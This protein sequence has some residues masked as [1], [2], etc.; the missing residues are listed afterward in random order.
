[1]PHFYNSLNP[2]CLGYGRNFRGPRPQTNIVFQRASYRAITPQRCCLTA[3]HD[4]TG[5]T[6]HDIT[7][8]N[9]TQ[10]HSTLHCA[11]FIAPHSTTLHHTTLQAREQYDDTTEAMIGMRK[12]EKRNGMERKGCVHLSHRTMQRH[13]TPRCKL[14]DN[15]KKQGVVHT[16]VTS[17]HATPHHTKLQ[18][19]GAEGR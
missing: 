12:A 19:R 3:W 14:E 6:R 17:H 18:A 9:N 16:H 5:N 15:K 4:S 13:T 2:K 11:R 8:H 10:H 1:M 7:L